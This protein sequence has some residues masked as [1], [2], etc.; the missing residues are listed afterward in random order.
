MVLMVKVVLRP[1]TVCQD[2]CEM[3]TA[4]PRDNKTENIKSRIFSQEAHSSPSTTVRAATI[5][6]HFCAHN[7]I[8]IYVKGDKWIKN[9]ATFS[10]IAD[11]Q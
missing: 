1:S 8:R 11:A 7:R 6:A 4:P 3:I 5:T 10:T 9:G 2:I